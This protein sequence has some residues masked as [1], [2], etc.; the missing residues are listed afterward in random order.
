VALAH[1]VEN[2]MMSP[3][4]MNRASAFWIDTASG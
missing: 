2:R 4:N 3:R 1:G